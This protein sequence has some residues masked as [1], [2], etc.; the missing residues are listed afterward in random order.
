MKWIKL[1]Y[2]PIVISFYCSLGKEGFWP[3]WI[4][5]RKTRGVAHS[6]ELQSMYQNDKLQVYDDNILL[7]MIKPLSNTTFANGICTSS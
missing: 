6:D 2:N 4:F 7:I 1:R 3:R 5:K